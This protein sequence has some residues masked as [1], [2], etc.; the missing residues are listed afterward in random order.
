MIAPSL[1]SRERALVLASDMTFFSALLPSRLA[2]CRRDG[3]GRATCYACIAANSPRRAYISASYGP[4][5]NIFCQ[6]SVAALTVSPAQS[7]N[8]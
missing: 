4:I 8:S 5:A 3:P 2:F 6:T 7:L 1:A